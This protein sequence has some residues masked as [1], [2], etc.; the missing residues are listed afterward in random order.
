MQHRKEEKKREKR[1]SVSQ[2]DLSTKN[3]DVNKRKK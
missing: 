3:G 1:K 2:S